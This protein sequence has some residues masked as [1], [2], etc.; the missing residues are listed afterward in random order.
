METI[1]ELILEGKGLDC[2]CF[3]AR[4]TDWNKG[5]KER[6]RIVLKVTLTMYST[7]MLLL[8]V[9]IIGFYYVTAAAG[10]YSVTAAAGFY[11]VTVAAR[12]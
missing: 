12:F 4:R 7:F 6:Y 3:L 11:Y 2:L 5:D 1:N 9:N 10:F 8:F